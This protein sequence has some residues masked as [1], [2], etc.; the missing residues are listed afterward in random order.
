VLRALAGRGVALLCCLA[1]VAF[2]EV[3]P[4]HSVLQGSHHDFSSSAIATEGACSV[5]HRPHKA[6]VSAIWPRSL[7][8][9]RAYF[10]YDGTPNPD[11]VPGTTLLCYDCHDDNAT[12]ISAAVDNSPPKGTST[13]P[14][15]YEPQDVAFGY[16]WG[17]PDDT[18]AQ[19][20]TKT[21]YSELIDGRD[22]GTPS[23]PTDGTP[24]GGHYWKSDPSGTPDYRAGDKIACGY[25][26][27]PHN[28]RTGSPTRNEAFFLASTTLP[29]GSTVTPGGGLTASDKDDTT[30][31]NR[32]RYGTGTGREMC[33]AC[34]G[35]SLTGALATFGGGTVPRPKTSIS[36]HLEGN[37]TPCTLC[38]PH[39]RVYASCTD[40]HAY[41]PLRTIA[42]AGGLAFDKTLRNDVENYDGG[43]GAHQ[44]HKDALGEAIFRC[45]ICHGPDA[46]SAAWHNF[47]N[48]TFPGSNPGQNV[49][50]MG[51]SVYWDPGNT[52][53]SRLYTGAFSS[54][55]AQT[56]YEVPAKGGGDQRCANF[57]CHG[58]PPDN[59][60]DLNWTDDMVDGD[61]PDPIAGP[62]L[63]ICKWC[64][65]ATPAVVDFGSGPIVAPNVMGTGGSRATAA[66]F[67][68]EVNGHGLPDTVKYDKDAVA[69]ATPGG[70]DGAGKECTVCHDATYI[71]N[72]APT[73][74]TNIP[75]RTHFD[76]AYGS[77]QKRLNGTINA[78]PVAGPNDACVACHQHSGT[79]AGSQKP[80]HTN[81]T[82]PYHG[83]P[84]QQL[85]ADF[86][87]TCR[88]CHD[89]H[90]G[91]WNE[92]TGTRNKNMIGKWLDLDHDGQ[93]DA[94]E[95]GRVDTSNNGTV[96]TEDGGGVA[97]TARTGANSYDTNNGQPTRNVCL[98]CHVPDAG[99]AVWPGTGVGTGGGS[100][101]GSA[102]MSSD[103]RGNDCMQCHA[104]VDP[105]TVTTDP[106]ANWNGAFLPSGCEGCHGK[107]CN[108]NKGKDGV[109]G[110]P[111]DAPNVMTTNCSFPPGLSVW[112][113]AWWESTQGG[114]A[115]TQQGGHGDPDGKEGG[116][117][118]LTPG[119]LKC[120]NTADPP[121]THLNGVY[122]S[123]GTEIP[124]PFAPWNRNAPRPKLNQNANTS[125]LL[126]AYFTKYPGGA[127]DSALQVTMDN[128]CYRECH[129]ANS[130]KFMGHDA[131][132]PVGD[133]GY[134]PVLLGTHLTRTTPVSNNLVPAWPVAPFIDSDVSTTVAGAPNHA[135]CVSCHNPH[136]TMVT[137]TKAKGT[138]QEASGTNRMLIDDW[139]QPSTLCVD[140]HN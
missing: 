40:C 55:A 54:E 116:A 16:T 137:D 8:E 25:C 52:R 37:S 2:L 65:D 33:A 105:A 110:T 41:P 135:P 88:Q 68:A 43:A 67:G 114:N 36:Q 103:E 26:H 99:G 119:C 126:P 31:P 92:W 90:G 59:L 100:H 61:I 80:H 38:H 70:A 139:R 140:C 57:A 17:L 95:S 19:G 78:Q 133:P 98:T 101:F 112:D 6:D 13:W 48:G 34:H 102:N 125:H 106:V 115:A 7:A 86:N 72:P 42:Q 60:G 11:Y 63:R 9:E 136:G 4:A 5:C 53:S 132:L 107:D 96:G 56:G 130:V 77:A 22:P 50:I 21:G 10:T 81:L 18:F 121:A 108:V 76:S 128:Y 14:S 15:G 1:S 47:G 69:E 62:D 93:A 122:N 39:N 134:G 87:R 85:E 71:D 123:L 131:D 118:A 109:A 46:G 45:E 12:T 35:Y 28:T 20:G 30:N 3:R 32:S 124:M 51:Q 111:D 58:Y 82:G 44:R 64:H 91:S 113:G 129:A 84:S 75:N 138:V 117:A 74:P 66:N 83:P 24:T 79:D 127:G 49:D 23:P 104:H 89:V 94:G 120:H 97:F 73:L 27:D 29:G